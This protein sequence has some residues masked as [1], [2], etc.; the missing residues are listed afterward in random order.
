MTVLRRLVDVVLGVSGRTGSS[1]EE[2]NAALVCDV[3]RAPAVFLR[4]HLAAVHQ[5][6]ANE[7]GSD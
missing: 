5:G 7:E 4:R 6:M 1:D 3:G 2:E